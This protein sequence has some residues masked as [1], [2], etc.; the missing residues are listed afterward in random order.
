[1]PSLAEHH[2]SKFIKLFYIGD[3]GTGKTGSL[4]SLVEAGYRLR[5]LDLD[6]G[7]DA[8]REYAKVRCP[9]RLGQIDYETRRDR[10]KA[11]A[12]G[13]VLQG[14][15][16][17]FTDCLKL[18]D[19]WTDESSP[20]EWGENTIFVLDSLTTYGKAAFEWAKGMN[21]GAKDPR[22]WYFAAQQAVEDTVAMLTGDDFQCNVLV[23][24]HVSYNEDADGIRRGYTSAIGSALG[25]K[26]PKYL[27]TLILAERSGTGQNV[28]R[29][30]RT[31][32]TTLVDLKV[33]LPNLPGTLPL[34]SGLAEIFKQLKSNS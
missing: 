9:D 29:V 33:P 18:M 8:L 21:T 28:K 14:Q 31:L 20:R 6:N 30:I 15:P 16:K 32:P 22:Q 25:P 24:S 3:S 1:M 12:G 4:V 10:Y 27:N 7:L 11:S 34:E 19:K 5:I 26:L 23:I 2:G 13:P 17:A